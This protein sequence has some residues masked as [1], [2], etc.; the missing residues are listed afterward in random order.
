MKVFENATFISCED[1]NRFFSVLVEDKGKIVFV[2]DAIPEEYKKAERI[3]LQSKCVVPA[4][5]DAHI[6]F[7]SYALFNNT[8]DVR[9]ARNYDEVISIIQSYD[10]ANPAEKILIGFGFSEHSIAEKKAM[11]RHILD[12]AI[13]KPL[14]LVKYDGHAAL[15]NSALLKKL[16]SSVFAQRGVDSE[17]GWLLN[18]AFFHGVNYISSLI[19][20]YRL[21]KNL[22]NANH[23]MAKKGIGLIDTAEGVGFPLDADIHTMRFASLGLPLSYRIYQQTMDVKKVVSRKNNF[24]GGCF[25]TALD[26]CFGSEDAALLKPYSNNPHNSGVLF[27]N[28][29]TVNNFVREANRANL[30]VALHAIGDAAVEQALQAYEF[31]LNDYPR[32]DHRHIII[33]AF[34]MT[35]NQIERTGKMGIHISTQPALISWAQEPMEYIE[36]LL[37]TRTQ[38]M[39]NLNK[40]LQHN[41]TIAAGSDAPCSLPDPM[42]SIYAACKHPIDGYG[43]SVLDALKMHTNWGAKLSF[44]E[45]ERGTLTVGKCA[46]FVLLDKNPLTTAIAEIPNITIEKFYLNGNEYRDD[47]KTPYDLV[48]AS[49]KN[50]LFS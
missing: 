12:K 27:Y 46:D 7:L 15:C 23:S 2:G 26:G 16:P 24:I 3:N 45:K 6:H 48:K 20:P 14:L 38:N 30:Q 34:L 21:F 22:I 11:D 42:F 33:H 18:D 32:E 28:Q 40:M 4:F 29:E 1:G 31:A 17:S 47:I 25:K 8:F 9:N 13:K 49:I 10:I 39:L 5:V 41:I 19:S 37:G 50:K 44:D 35:E 43:I 36:T